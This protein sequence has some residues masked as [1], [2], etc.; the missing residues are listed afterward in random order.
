MLPAPTIDF[1]AEP[2]VADPPARV[3]RDW[4]LLG[5]LVV[6]LTCE[7]IFN[8]QLIWRPLHIAAVLAIIPTVL[9]RRTHPLLML[10]IA[11]VLTNVVTI[12]AVIFAEMPEGPYTAAFVLITVYALF[13]WGSGRHCAIGLAMLMAVVLLHFFID[14]G[15]IAETIGGILVVLAPAE[16][17]V[18]VRYQKRSAEQAVT[19]AQ[20]LERERI[21]RELHDSVAHHVSAIAIQAQAGRAVAA[22]NPAAAAQALET[23]EEA[24]ARTLS[25]MRSMVGSL[26]GD[27]DAE[28]TPQQG[29]S[30]IASL[31][32]S[33]GGIV[34]RVADLPEPSSTQGTTAVG[35]AL[36]RIAQES[37]TNAVRHADGAT[38]VDVQLTNGSDRYTLTVRDDGR[39]AGV[40][41]KP[42]GYGLIG[43][44]ERARLLGGS[45][46]AGPAHDGGWLVKAELPV[47]GE[48]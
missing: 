21:A 24:A 1:F 5:A 36:F 6:C 31:A 20:A 3:D 23:I 30:D 40:D 28:L 38:R 34:V 11:M 4:W 47:G 2:A 45:L 15:G 29:M 22:N 17:G 7:A 43:M 41:G 32:G 18:L 35:A 48:V 25:D 33:T 39:G 26:R 12:L 8:T 14:Y 13:R 16:L 19:E 42:A 46:E 44:A 10:T 37:V 27:S 9:W